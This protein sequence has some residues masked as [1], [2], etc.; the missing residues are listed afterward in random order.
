VYPRHKLISIPKF[1]RFS[2]FSCRY[3]DFLYRVLSNN[4]IPTLEDHKSIHGPT[5]GMQFNGSGI[6]AHEKLSYLFSVWRM[7]GDWSNGSKD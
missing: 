2:S 3:I 1:Q 4:E 6:L 5:S 7:E